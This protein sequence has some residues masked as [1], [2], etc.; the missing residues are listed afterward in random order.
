MRT[1]N[2]TPT[3]LREVVVAFLQFPKNPANPNYEAEIPPD[4]ISG[5]LANAFIFI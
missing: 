1:Y 2:E 3:T 4:I 5:W